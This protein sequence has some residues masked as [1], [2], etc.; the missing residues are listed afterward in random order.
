MKRII[1]S[2][3]TFILLTAC[4]HNNGD[5]GDLFGKWQ[6]Q[7]VKNEKET[8]SY[9]HIFYNFQHAVV[10][11][12][13]LESTH[14]VKDARGYFIHEQDSLHLHMVDLS[15]TVYIHRFALPDTAVAFE[16]KKLTRNE[17]VLSHEG[18]EWFLKKY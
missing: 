7:E 4:T 3:V 18:S 6:L 5:I 8:I 17:M 14:V 12:Q 2:A 1:L 15:D 13:Y 11:L 10:I 16:I 9:N